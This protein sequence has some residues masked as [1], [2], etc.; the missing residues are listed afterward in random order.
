MMESDFVHVALE[1]VR[2]RVQYAGKGERVGS[3]EGVD[4]E[5]P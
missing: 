3:P 4:T 1:D 5:V 2:A